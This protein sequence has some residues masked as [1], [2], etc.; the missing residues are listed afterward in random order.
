MATTAILFPGT[1]DVSGTE[2]KTWANPNNVKVDDGSYATQVPQSYV[3]SR[4]MRCTNFGFT[5]PSTSTVNGITLTIKRRRSGGTQGDVGDDLIRVLLAG[6]GT[7]T[8]QA[9]AGYW[10]TSIVTQTYGGPALLM[11][12]TTAPLYSDVNN[13]NFGCQIRLYGTQFIPNDRNADID[14]VGMQIDYTDTAE[15]GPPSNL[16]WALWGYSS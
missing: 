5:L 12:L 1:V 14:V 3:N 7:G 9:T 6:V 13:V 15:S 16:Y 11:G 4:V 10:G 8:N 2:S